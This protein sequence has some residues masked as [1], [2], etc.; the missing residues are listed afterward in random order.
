MVVVRFVSPNLF[1]C[2]DK[3]NGKYKDALTKAEVKPE[4]V[5]ANKKAPVAPAAAAAPAAS[6]AAAAASEEAGAQEDGKPAAKQDDGYRGMYDDLVVHHRQTE[7]KH[8]EAMQDLKNE[9]EADKK[10]LKEANEAEKKKVG[11]Y[12]RANEKLERRVAEKDKEIAKLRE[13]LGNAK[14]ANAKVPA[15]L[16]KKRKN[17]ATEEAPK[18]KQ[19]TEQDK[20]TP[21]CV[22]LKTRLLPVF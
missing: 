14:F 7:Q 4:D 11:E 12:K 9:H 8:K 19:N 2:A 16:N 15:G 6:A 1:F 18:K 21:N 10:K 13:E 3:Q 20:V 5:K 22:N 17:A